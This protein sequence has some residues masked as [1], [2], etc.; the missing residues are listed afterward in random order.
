MSVHVLGQFTFCGRAG[1]YSAENGDETDLDEPAPRLTYLPNFDLERIEEQL[2]KVIREFWTMSFLGFIT[3]LLMVIAVKVQYEL[4]F[5][6]A[7]AGSLLCLQQVVSLAGMMFVLMRRRRAAQRAEA[8]EPS[9]TIDRIEPVNWWSML[10]AGF[11][12]KDYQRQF[13]HPELRLEGCPW[14]VLE[15]ASL[16][17]PVIKSG[18]DK[19]GD[20]KHALYPKHEVRL[21]AYAVLLEATQHVQVPYGL[22]FPSDSHIGLAVPITNAL[23]DQVRERLDRSWRTIAEPGVRAATTPRSKMCWL[24]AGDTCSHQRSRSW[25]G[26]ESRVTDS[27]SARQSRTQISLCLR[28]PIRFSAAA[29]SDNSTRLD[30]GH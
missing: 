21:A 1:I 12:R 16:R 25:H 2:S 19:L 17:I 5:Y 18:A 23:R 10:K 29:Q 28:R 26:K 8:R 24:P 6:P 3:I 20:A 7:L 11:D 13:R 22:I 15:R 14:C 30:G 9:P 27:P 4:M